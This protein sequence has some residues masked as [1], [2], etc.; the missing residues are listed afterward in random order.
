VVQDFPDGKVFVAANGGSDLIYVPSHDRTVVANVVDFLTKQDYVSG[1]FVD[2][3]FGQL[4]GALPLSAIGLKGRTELPVPAIAVNYRTFATDPGNRL[5]TAVQI[6]D[7][8]LQE[9]QGMHGTLSRDNTFNNMAAMGPDFKKGYVDRFPVANRDIPVTLAH[10]MG[11]SIPN[12]D[13][14]V[15]TEA[16]AGGGR[17]KQASQA[18]VLQS[19][20]TSDGVYTV[21]LYQKMGRYLYFDEACFATDATISAENPCIP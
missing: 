19:A 2:D 18:L 20:R 17:P 12:A 11:L 4:P 10:L 13:G 9:G 8:T 1:L 6:A 3:I 7:S 5:M 21:L 16:L 14:R 15:V